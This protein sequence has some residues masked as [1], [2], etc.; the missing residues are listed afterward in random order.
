MKCPKCSA[1]NGRVI[2]SRP[3]AIGITRRRE[4]DRCAHRWSTKEVDESTLMKMN[5]IK[6]REEFMEIAQSELNKA[7]FRI[8]EELKK[9][10]RPD[11]EEASN[12]EVVSFTDRRFRRA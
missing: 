2:D 8:M 1:A 10:T 5:K 7:Y 3:I 6:M 9:A 11:E 4:C 12:I